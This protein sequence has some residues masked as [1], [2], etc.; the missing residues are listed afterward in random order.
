MT[1]VS[2]AIGIICKVPVPGRSKTRLAA[3]IGADAAAQLSAC[4]LQD[5]A[6]TIDRLPKHFACCGYAVYAPEGAEAELR[7]LLPSPFGLMLQADTE[8]GRVLLRTTSDFLAAGHD[9]AVLVNGD[10]PTLPPQ[11]LTQAIEALRRPGDRMV[12][13]PAADGGYYLIGLKAAHR[14]LFTGIPWGTDSVAR[15]TL[16]RASEIGLD[17]V[18]LP[19]WYDIDDAETLGWLREE[20]S[21]RSG[22][23]RDG[24]SAEATRACLDAMAAGAM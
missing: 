24:A 16:G 15:V 3:T 12:L 19:E 17:I 6:R 2:A 10:S 5:V 18:C 9:C 8:L 22:R 23:F 20:L 21:G 11:L 13:G 1:T 4:F 14:H 7:R